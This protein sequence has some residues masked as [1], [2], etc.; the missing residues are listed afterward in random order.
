M[1]QFEKHIRENKQLFDDKKPAKE[2]M[3]QAISEELDATETKVI[4]LWKSPKIRVAA[5]IVIILGIVG[6]FSL[7]FMNSFNNTAI[8]SEENIELKEINSHY[9]GIVAYHVQLVEANTNLSSED[10]KEFLS[11]MDELDE[12]YENLK[13]EMNQD[14]DNELVLEAIIKNYKKRI[15]LIENLLTQINNS[16][17]IDSDEA[18][19][20]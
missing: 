2:K 13:L 1:D 17:K 12:E 18:Y 3:W 7:N 4:P 16:K 15:E 14:L 11:F 19:I 8:N 6:F 20:L 9:Q 5:S 10:K